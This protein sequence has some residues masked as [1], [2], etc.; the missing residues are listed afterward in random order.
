MS[1]QTKVD[2]NITQDFTDE[3]KGLA[4]LNIGAADSTTLSILSNNVSGLSYQVAANTDALATMKWTKVDVDDLV[5]V[6]AT[7]L[8]T[9]G[10]LIIGYF[11]DNSTYFRISMKSTS[12]TR[13]IYLSDNMGYGGGYQ[14]SD[15]SWNTITMHGFT[16]ACQYE[17]FLGYDCTADLPIHFE[18]QFAN[19]GVSSFTTV[20]RY[21][22]LEG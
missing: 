2:V 5:T 21:R 4:R 10:N 15:S 14:V 11:F 17:S 6:P 22:I 9:V 19:S 1:Q 16:N 12:G 3:Q 8:F 18:V 20:C 13:Y 7:Q